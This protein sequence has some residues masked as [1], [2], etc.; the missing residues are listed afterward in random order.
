[1]L[2]DVEL[3]N[4]PTVVA[5][6]KKAVEH[7]ESDCWHGEEVHGRKGFSMVTQERKPGFRKHRIS[8]CFAHPAGDGSLGNVEAEHEK[9][10]MNPRCSPGRI[11][12]GH[13]GNQNLGSLL[14]FIFCQPVQ[15]TWK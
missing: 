15:G 12:G 10:T 14:K 1:V 11:F 6:D 2:R 4:A 8:R 9:F 3:Q 7:T 13:P 5:D